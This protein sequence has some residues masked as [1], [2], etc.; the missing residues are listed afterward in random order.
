MSSDREPAE[1]PVSRE[2]SAS[3]AAEAPPRAWRGRLAV[4]AAILVALCALLPALVD[5][6]WRSDA[7]SPAAAP[8]SAADAPSSTGAQDTP[9][10]AAPRD[11]QAPAAPSTASHQAID[12]EKIAR[13]EEAL[14]SLTAA[15]DEVHRRESAMSATLERRLAGLERRLAA[16]PREAPPSP[17][18]SPPAVSPSTARG[19][20]APGVDLTPLER[21]V[22]EVE[23]A[24]QAEGSARLAFQE[25]LL[26]RMFNLETSRNAM[27][28]EHLSAQR[29][30]A[31]RIYNLEQRIHVTEQ[32]QSE[33][34]TRLQSIARER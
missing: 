8:A 28:A 26:A 23:R 33:I 21:R 11:G 34:E 15:L 5:Y 19:S 7:D 29:S 16:L 1:P 3:C 31:D 17:A 12:P 25:S 27:D 4:V 20:D 13:L 9:V 14:A 10:P 24:M 18:P 30:L 2:A 32:R 6:G 22:L